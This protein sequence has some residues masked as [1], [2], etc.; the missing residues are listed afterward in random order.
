LRQYALNTRG[1]VKQIFLVHGEDK[2]AG[3]LMELLGEDG[4]QRVSYPELHSSVEI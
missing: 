3:A 1:S 4:L 2:P